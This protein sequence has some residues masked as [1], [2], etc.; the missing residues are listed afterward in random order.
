MSCTTCLSKLSTLFAWPIR[1]LKPASQAPA[2]GAIYASQPVIMAELGTA[3]PWL[4]HGTPLY[5]S[6]FDTNIGIFVKKFGQPVPLPSLPSVS[7]CRGLRPRCSYMSTRNGSGRTQFRSATSA[8]L[9]V[10]LRAE[11]KVGLRTDMSDHCQSAYPVQ[12][13]RIILC[14]GTSTTSWYLYMR[15]SLSP[16]T[17]QKS[18]QHSPCQRVC[19]A[20]YFTALGLA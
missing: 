12:A 19:A 7:C 3:I 11:S 10:R 20:E 6:S 1:L 8:E 13:G 15:E 2:G 5:L 17:P 9:L 18:Q 4:P 14:H 16:L